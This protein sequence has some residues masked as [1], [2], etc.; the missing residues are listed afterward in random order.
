MAKLAL[1]RG[2][3]GSHR[4]VSRVERGDEASD[5]SSLAGGIPPFEEHE[6]GWSERAVADEACIDQPQ[7]EEVSLRCKQPGL[8]LLL[9]QMGGQIDGGER[10][11]HAPIVPLR[12]DATRAPGEPDA[13]VLA[14]VG[15]A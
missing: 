12:P 10:E 5:R 4:D 11:G 1:R 13:L 2:G 8:C 14:G 7:V 6:E 3:K 15:D 9:G